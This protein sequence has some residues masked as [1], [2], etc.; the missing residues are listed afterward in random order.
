[1]NTTEADRLVRTALH[2]VAPEADLSRLRPDADLRDTL[3]LDSLDFLNLVEL[4]SSR[5][6]KRIDEE[7]YPRLGTL[8]DIVAYL[9]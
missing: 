4:L 7:D 1:M 5:S 3:A 9:G 6:G 2:E 8:A